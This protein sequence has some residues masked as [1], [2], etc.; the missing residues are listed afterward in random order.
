VHIAASLAIWG[1]L[2]QPILE[3][4]ASKTRLTDHSGDTD[5]GQTLR[6]LPMSRELRGANVSYRLLEVTIPKQVV[7]AMRLGQPEVQ[8]HHPLQGERSLLYLAIPAARNPGR[9]S[10]EARCRA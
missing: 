7:A 1:I 3:Q 10:V 9:L 4:I 2:D 5:D 8:R 6:E